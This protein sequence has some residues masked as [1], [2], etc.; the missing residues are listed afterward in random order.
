MTLRIEVDARLLS[1]GGIG[2]YL[3]EL[4]A[5]WLGHPDVSRMRFFGH[6]AELEAFL[7]RTDVRS[8]AEVVS[9]IDPPYRPEAQ[10]RWPGVARAGG[11]PADVSFFPHYDVPLFRHPRPSVVTVHD[12]IHFQE[13]EGFP[14]WKRAVGLALLR[15]ALERATVVVTVSEASR[16]AI[17]EMMPSVSGKVHVVPNGV[18]APFRAD[19]GQASG[20]ASGGGVSPEHGPFILCVGRDKRYKNL[21]HAVRTLAHLPER[22]GWRLVLVGPTERAAQEVAVRAGHAELAHRIVATGPVT[23]EALRSL[24]VAAK[25][26]LVPSTLEGFGLPVLEARACGAPV[27]AAD[28]P[29]SRELSPSGVTLMRGWSGAAW[30]RAVCDG[31]RGGDALP[32]RAW[33]WDTAADRTLELL[34]GAAE[35]GAR[36]GG[37]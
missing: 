33:R 6:R 10:L 26:V 7:E 34:R 1:A 22:E 35:V 17:C 2:R 19:R 18:G 12:L 27:I 16:H 32:A 3:R 9:W 21:E 25:A 24:Y 36:P 29:W 8:V 37:V 13:P 30:A 11:W 14:A 31:R 4:T 5:R 15:G 20:D 28:L 23:D